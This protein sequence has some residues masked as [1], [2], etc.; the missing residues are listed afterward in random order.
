MGNPASSAGLNLV[1]LKRR[2]FDREA[3]H[4]LR[5]AYRMIFSSEGTLRERVEDA[6]AIFPNEQ[7]VQDVVKFIIAA[8]DHPLTLPRNGHER[9]L[10]ARRLTLVAGSGALAPL[11]AAARPAPWRYAAGHRSRRPRRHRRRPRRDDS[12][13]R[14]RRD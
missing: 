6:A 9:G 3:I 2:G 5:A 4:K 11:V 1:G 7:L 14:R 13:V 10:M 8:K 12:A